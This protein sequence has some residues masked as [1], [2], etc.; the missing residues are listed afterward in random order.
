MTINTPTV[1]NWEKG[2]SAVQVR[3]CPEML[4][5]VSHLFHPARTPLLNNIKNEVNHE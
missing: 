2:D 4:R 3:F 5:G 1:L